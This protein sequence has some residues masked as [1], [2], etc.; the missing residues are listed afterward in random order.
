MTAAKRNQFEEIIDQIMIDEVSGL[1]KDIRATLEGLPI[2]KKRMAILSILDK[3]RDMFLKIKELVKS[4][5]VSKKHYTKHVVEMLR[6]YVKVGEVEKKTLGEV[7]RSE[8]HTSELQ[9]L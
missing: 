9:S 8:E 4:D 7:M 3:D 6:E 1:D 2:S 5:T